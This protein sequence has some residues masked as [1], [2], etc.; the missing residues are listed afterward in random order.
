MKGSVCFVGG[1]V[2]TLLGRPDGGSERQIALI[3]SEMASRGNRVSLVVPGPGE[4]CSLHGI[5]VLPGWADAGGWPKGI[6]FF[7]HRL[8]LLKGAIR[9]Q[10]PDLL[11]TRG[12]SMFAPAV[13][14][15]AGKTGATYLAALACDDDLRERA[16]SR[17]LGFVQRAGYGSAA[18]RF[19][20]RQA[21]GRADLVLAQH[22]GQAAACER[23]GIASRVVR[24]VFIPP[25]AVPEAGKVYDAAWVGHVSEFKGFDRLLGVLKR[26]G[27]LRVAV[28]G[29][30]QG[31]RNHR[32]LREAEGVKGIEYMG[33]L[34][35][36][37]VLELVSASGVLLNTSP[38]EGF[39]NTFLEAWYLERPVVSLVSDPDELLSGEGPLGF[40]G[41]GS[42]RATAEALMRLCADQAS[43]REMGARGRLHVL[44]HHMVAGVVDSLEEAWRSARDLS[45]DPARHSHPAAGQA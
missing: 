12:F 45:N 10:E 29:A 35:H 6:R 43:R 27:G 37:Q 44:R 16:L 23:M 26:T 30:V 13:A 36:S 22:G 20:I 2:G 3:A 25:A 5:R 11:Y 19:F 40:C 21:L 4:E 1:G 33:E 18:R 14:S 38:A 34:P 8:P 28:A 42:V 24:N 15:V 17:P 7:T 32:L 41:A 9:S 31:T 39:P